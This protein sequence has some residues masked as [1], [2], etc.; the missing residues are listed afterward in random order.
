[1]THFHAIIRTHSNFKHY[2]L[3]MNNLFHYSIRNSLFGVSNYHKQPSLFD[4]KYL[5]YLSH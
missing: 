1:M 5:M 4:I 2:I 3:T